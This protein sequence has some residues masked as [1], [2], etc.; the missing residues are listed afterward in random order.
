MSYENIK[1]FRTRLKERAVYVMGGKCQC[2]GY[3]KCIQAL[4]FHHI[5]PNEKEF[6]F[7]SNTNRSWKDTRKELQKCILLCANCHRETHFGM[8]AEDKFTSSFSEERAQEID[9]LVEEI[10]NYNTCKMC[11]AKIGTNSEYCNKCAHI[12]ARVSERPSREELKKLIR[13]I[14]FTQIGK[15]FGVTDNAI[16]KWCK[17]MNLPSKSSDIKSYT[18]EEWQ[19]I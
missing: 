4:E 6:S 8:I 15:Q 12:K 5:N 1:N 9:S 2:C 17:S 7:G 14:P 3:D 11:G 19:D 18:D 10:K 16:R 13:T